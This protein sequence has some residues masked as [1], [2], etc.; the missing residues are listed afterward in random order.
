MGYSIGVHMNNR[1]ILVIACAA[2]LS[3]HVTNSID[4]GYTFQYTKNRD[5]RSTIEALLRQTK[6]ILNFDASAVVRGW[7][8][9]FIVS[10]IWMDLDM[11][12]GVRWKYLTF[13]KDMYLTA[14]AHGGVRAG[15]DWE[16][17]GQTGTQ[18]GGIAPLLHVSAD[19]TL[20]CFRFEANETMT[21]FTDGVWFETTPMLS[22]TIIDRIELRAGFTL[23]NGLLYSGN[24]AA[25]NFA[26]IGG[27]GWRFGIE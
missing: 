11:L 1:I 16:R 9:P 4:V 17:F 10:W 2:V 27:A 26:F 20:D 8:S 18:W 23:V 3:A 7:Y 25:Y 15:V 21:V 14:A 22:V 6:D 5:N 13:G 24:A 19:V 12:A